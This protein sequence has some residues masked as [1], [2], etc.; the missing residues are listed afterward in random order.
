MQTTVKGRKVSADSLLWGYSSFKDDIGLFA[1]ICHV[2]GG[3][4]WKSLLY[5]ESALLKTAFKSCLSLTW[6]LEFDSDFSEGCSG[7]LGHCI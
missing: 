4:G 5:N 7:V 6:S 1:I 3:S 2:T